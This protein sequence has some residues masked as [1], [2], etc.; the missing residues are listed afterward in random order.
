V[1]V[2]V[3]QSA[4]GVAEHCVDTLT[5]SA[6]CFAWQVAHSTLEIFAGSGKSLIAVWQSLQPRM[7]C[8]LAACFCRRMG[9]I[10][11]L[12]RFHA[13]LPVAGETSLILHQGL[14]GFFLVAGKGGRES[15]ARRISK[16]A[17]AASQ[18]K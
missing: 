6:A 4:S 16:A 18:S 3:T 14:S 5:E 12:F 2:A 7:P 15:H 11:A 1:V 8:T 17:Q 13:R 10:H 9:N